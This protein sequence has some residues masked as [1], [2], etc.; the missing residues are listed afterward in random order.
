M[1]TEGRKCKIEIDT[2]FLTLCFLAFVGLRQNHG[3]VF[4]YNLVYQSILEALPQDI[5]NSIFN[6]V[7]LSAINRLELHGGNLGSGAVT[8]MLSVSS[9]ILH[10]LP[11]TI[12]P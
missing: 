9:A 4:K 3:F 5:C 7:L 11:V 12:I 1:A 6:I 10:L 8:K 2:P